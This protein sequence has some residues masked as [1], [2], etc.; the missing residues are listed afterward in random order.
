[1]KTDIILAIFGSTGLF[2][3]IQFN[4]YKSGQEKGE[5]D[6]SEGFACGNS[7]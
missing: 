1:M 5:P 4:R 7:T 2:S 3:L 6:G